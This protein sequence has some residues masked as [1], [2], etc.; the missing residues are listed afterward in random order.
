VYTHPDEQLYMLEL[1]LRDD[2]LDPERV[3]VLATTQ[4]QSW[5]LRKLAA[6]F[7]SLPQPG[8]VETTPDATN[9]DSA[10]P[11]RSDSGKAAKLAQYYERRRKAM[12]SKQW[13]GKRLLLAMVDR[14]MGG[15]GTVVYYVVQEGNVKPRQN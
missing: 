1:G 6:V 10:E 7:D 4:G 8:S 11:A 15:D 12:V 13:G 2:D 9:A 3:F 5:T 14:E